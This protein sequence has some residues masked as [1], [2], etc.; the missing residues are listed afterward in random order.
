MTEVRM[1]N[2]EAC[3]LRIA[4]SEHDETSSYE[5]V[6]SDKP[7]KSSHRYLRV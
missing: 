3:C 6:G 5:I 7:N 1:Y 2:A 4:L